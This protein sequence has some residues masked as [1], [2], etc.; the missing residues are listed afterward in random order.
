VDYK[1]AHLEFDGAADALQRAR[2][3]FE[4]QLTTYASVLRSLRGDEFRIHAGIYYP[5]TRLFDWWQ[6]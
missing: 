1:T 6:I 3:L 2:V 5:R 4:S